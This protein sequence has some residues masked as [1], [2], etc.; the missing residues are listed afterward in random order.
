MLKR[1]L[2][3]IRYNTFLFGMG[4]FLALYS[5]YELN[6]PT[7]PSFMLIFGIPLYFIGAVIGLGMMGACFLLSDKT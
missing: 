4:A 3:A 2:F 7:I 1:L 6:Q 5:A